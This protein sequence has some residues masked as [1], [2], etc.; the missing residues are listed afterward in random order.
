MGLLTA[1]TVLYI[2]VNFASSQNYKPSRYLEVPQFDSAA[3]DSDEAPIINLNLQVPK[4][5]AA[6]LFNSYAP[7]QNEQNYYNNDRYD[8]PVPSEYLQVPNQQWNPNDDPALLYELPVEITK[9]VLPTNIHPK[10]YDKNVFGKIKPLSSKPKEEIVLVPITVEDYLQ[11]QKQQDKV[12][13]NFAKTENQ[14]TLTQKQ[15]QQAV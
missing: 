3:A 10:K 2:L 14:K 7:V 1:V 5:D 8:I 12:V 13:N 15:T 9:Q 6:Q 11:K 4:E